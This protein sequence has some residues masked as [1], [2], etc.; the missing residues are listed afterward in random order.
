MWVTIKL[1]EHKDFPYALNRTQCGISMKNKC[2]VCADE[3]QWGPGNQL[4][5]STPF[6]I[7]YES[8]LSMLILG[9]DSY[10]KLPERI[11]SSLALNQFI[12]FQH[13]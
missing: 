12:V 7:N 9:Y 8:S 4:Q 13:E 2:H 5:F 6:A 3:N 11:T 1:T 10:R